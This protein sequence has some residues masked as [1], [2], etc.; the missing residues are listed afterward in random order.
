MRRGR[1]DRTLFDLRLGTIVRHMSSDLAPVGLR[2]Y[3]EMVEL[4][5]QDGNY[6]AAADLERLWIDLRAECRFALLCGYSAA[7]FAAPDAGSALSVICREHSRSLSEC[8][9]PL[10]QFLL[11]SETDA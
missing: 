1:R 3:G 10:G 6:A 8:S 7:H 4:L 9:D 2:I 11:R 5:A